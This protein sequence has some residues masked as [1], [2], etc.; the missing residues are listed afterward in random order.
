MMMGFP[1][2]LAVLLFVLPWIAAA[3]GSMRRRE[4]ERRRAETARA[5]EHRGEH[6]GE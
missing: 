5:A 2:W 1:I 4:D 3:R 6:I